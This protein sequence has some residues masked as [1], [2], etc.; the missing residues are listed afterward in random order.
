MLMTLLKFGNF[1]AITY[2]FFYL[3]VDSVISY[4][5]LMSGK[6]IIIFSF[7][8]NHLEENDYEN[9]IEQNLDEL[10]LEAPGLKFVCVFLPRVLPA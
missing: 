5:H 1:I 7:S 6:K 8:K 3:F 4:V 9:W 2:H 10:W